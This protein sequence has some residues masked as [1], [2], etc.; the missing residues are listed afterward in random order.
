MT[1]TTREVVIAACGRSAVAKAYKGALHN[2]H[3]VELGGQVLRGVLDKLPQLNLNE[4]DDVII[5]CARPE[6]PQCSNIGRL[7]ML[8]AGIPSTIPAQ[9]LTRF[10]SSG[11]Q[12]IATGAN[13][14]MCGQQDIVVCGGVE[15][16]TCVK[17]GTPE[18]D[19]CPWLS[20][21]C[22][23][24]YIPMGLTA[25]NVAR[26]YGIT[27]L[28]MEEFAVE[29]HRKA[30]IAQA[31]G[32]FDDQIIP[33]MVQ[34]ADGN[35]VE[36]KRDEGIR[37]N[38]TVESLQK[39]KPAFCEDGLVTA[40]TASQM[41]DGAGMAVLMSAEK[42]RELGIT[43]VAKFIAHAVV[44]V[45]P[46][47]M[48]LGPIGAVRKLLA[49][50]GGSVDDFDVIE[51]N[52]AFAAQA[53]PCI[54]ELGFD[55]KKVNPNGGAIALGHPLGGTGAILLCKALSELKRIG[56]TRALVTMCIGGGMGAA[57]SFELL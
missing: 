55:L 13:A 12:A 52:E 27:R 57:A 18:E 26:K 4:I 34:D 45:D 1:Q 51:I 49:K 29:S 43:P 44:G 3:P 19:R 5:G 50:T 2:T 39:L 22:P 48:G 24:A 54:R 20:E 35:T 32:R 46:A 9:T 31:E 36:F 17:M 8:R 33:V 53:I 11:L 10:C 15:S 28:E 7:I 21:N 41:S 14:I 23:D 47:Y 30:A 25:E 16:M 37:P 56:K 6:G 38:S 40:A 42:A